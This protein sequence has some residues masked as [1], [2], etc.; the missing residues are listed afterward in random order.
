MPSYSGYILPIHTNLGSR[1]ALSS[2]PRSAIPQGRVRG[3][4]PQLAGHQLR[5]PDATPMVG[6]ETSR[7][8]TDCLDQHLCRSLSSDPF[9]TT[10]GSL[11]RSTAP[12]DD[13]GAL[14]ESPSPDSVG[15]RAT[16][17]GTAAAA[18]AGGL[19]RTGRSD[20]LGGRRRS[21]RKL[22]IYVSK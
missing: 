10:L 2:H 19:I 16:P 15:E 1:M 8:T 9:H 12:K 22:S 14:N 17:V 11:F 7:D 13:I 6:R 20:R 5:C 21:R 4:P 3:P 18:R